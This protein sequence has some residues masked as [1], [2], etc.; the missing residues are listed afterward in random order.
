MIALYG[1]VVVL[2]LS[3]YLLSLES[4]ALVLLLFLPIF[5]KFW[6][7]GLGEGGFAL[8][9]Q[10]VL[11]LQFLLLACL[12]VIRSRSFRTSL[13]SVMRCRR[14]PLVL[15]GIWLFWFLL[16]SAAAPRSLLTGV[17]ATGNIFVHGPALILIGF[18]LFRRAAHRDRALLVVYLATVVVGS[19][20]FWE[21][22]QSEPV[23][24][25]SE[26]QYETF[27]ENIEAGR[28]REGQYR[29][30][31]TFSNPLEL[32]VFFVGIVP[33]SFWGIIRGGHVAIRVAASFAFVCSTVGTVYTQSRAGLLVLI[34]E[35][36]V[37]SWYMFGS[38]RLT[39]T[40]I[41]KTV[42][43]I[44]LLLL[45]LLL[46]PLEIFNRFLTLGGETGLLSLAWR[47]LQ[48]DQGIGL[49]LQ[50]MV[51]GHGPTRNVLDVVDLQSIDILLLRIALEGGL[52]A[53]AAYGGFLLSSV[54]PGKGLGAG[55]R[56]ATALRLT[57]V[58]QVAMM[59]AVS[60]HYAFFIG[61]ICIGGL[62]A[63]ES[64]SEVSR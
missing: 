45:F 18:I 21:I 7:L 15:L 39:W 36:L 34:A 55:G 19:V 26:L 37:T 28:T 60:I 4:A 41:F 2:I 56:L 10:R 22:W 35:L 64:V 1:A 25:P 29:A 31:G 48:V 63:V 33:L 3:L 43:Y 17:V 20:V 30:M 38:T 50:Q 53:L 62:W 13:L 27:E 49:V 44:F 14:V 6:A 40:A 23:F 16:S 59:F 61:Y 58:F 32:A 42:P 5:P 52:V 9:L 47:L 51:L 54:L 24:Q 12:H 46:G 57:A 11:I 8:T